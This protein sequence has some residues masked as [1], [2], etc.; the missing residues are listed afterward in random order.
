M[1]AVS[2]MRVFQLAVTT[3]HDKGKNALMHRKWGQNE[4]DIGLIKLIS[5]YFK[6]ISLS[7]PFQC[8]CGKKALKSLYCLATHLLLE[9]A[10]SICVPMNAQKTM[11]GK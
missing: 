8:D 1:H 6:L 5:A 4:A 2:A 9:S 10:R 3:E 11:P 7:N